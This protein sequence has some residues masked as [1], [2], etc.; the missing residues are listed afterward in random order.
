MNKNNI[1]KQYEE[2]VERT[3]KL[4]GAIPCD[5]ESFARMR[6]AG[7]AGEVCILAGQDESAPQ[8]GKLK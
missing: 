5:F 1:N 8:E 7:L 4:E 2:Y 6:K 3:K